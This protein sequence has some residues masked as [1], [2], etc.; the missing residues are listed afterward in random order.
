[1]SLSFVLDEKLISS[2]KELDNTFSKMYAELS[3]CTQEERD[4]LYRYARVSTIGASTRIENAQLTDVEVNWLDTILTE[5]AHV[6][7]FLKNKE[8]I[9]NK[10][11]KDKERSIE[12]VTGC[13][14]ML[15]FIY[16]N[17]EDFF[18]LKENDLRALHHT[19]MS[20]YPKAHTYAGKYESI[21]NSVVE[22]NEKTKESGVVF[23]T[24]PAGQITQTSMKEL[25]DWYNQALPSFPWPIAVACEFVYR[26]LSIH[27]FQDGN[28]RLGR[29]LFLMS[30]LHS[31]SETISFVSKYLSIDRFVEKSR[32]EYYF[33]LN[34]CS[35][36]KF[37]QDPKNYHIEYFLKFM[38]KVLHEAIDNIPV[39][40]KRYTAEKLLSPSAS[41]VLKCFREFPEIRLTSRKIEKETN[42]P[43]RTIAYS[44]N[45]LLEN[46]LI[47]RYG[48]GAG[49]RYQ[50]VF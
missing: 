44:L 12:E 28:G 38:I 49:I 13:R 16:T 36:G 47:Q 33:T 19:L 27:P 11:S 31:K 48:Q 35:G 20:Y 3:N 29:G 24:A 7:S 34:R 37:D 40:R 18:P 45:I 32:Q 2:L 26:F 41:V 1:M 43:K 42:L 50:L 17:P 6:T 9:E 8:L 5:D 22:Y 46:H 39:L 14:E 10:L 25:V 30:L 21:P 23:E 15:L 4:S